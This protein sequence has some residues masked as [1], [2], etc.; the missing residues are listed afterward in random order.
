MMQGVVESKKANLRE[1]RIATGVDVL[2]VY[3][4]GQ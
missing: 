4:F 3:M 1:Y 2:V